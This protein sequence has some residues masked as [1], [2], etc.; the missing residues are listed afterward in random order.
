ME[1]LAIDYCRIF[2]GPKEFCPPCQSVWESGQFQGYVI[3]SMN[4]FLDIVDP[5][6][7]V[8]IR[9]HAG[10]QF[11]MMAIV[12]RYESEHPNESLGLSES[13]FR[14]HIAW[15]DRMLNRAAELAETDFYKSVLRMGAEFV[16]QEK[17]LYPVGG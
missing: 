13:F 11:E 17:S 7:E 5:Q 9:D 4:E 3:E 2:I 16:A 15:A 6:S 12:L 1:D 10:I 14:N 8:P